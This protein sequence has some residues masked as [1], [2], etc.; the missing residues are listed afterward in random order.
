MAA[1][2]AKRT[3]VVDPR[4]IDELAANDPALGPYFHECFGSD[5]EKLGAFLKR[6]MRETLEIVLDDCT[7]EDVLRLAALVEVRGRPDAFAAWRAR[8][9]GAGYVAPASRDA[10]HGRL[11]RRAR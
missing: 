7:I 9:A 5:R 10:S 1:T 4:G 6:F 3:D 8:V 2:K 11:D